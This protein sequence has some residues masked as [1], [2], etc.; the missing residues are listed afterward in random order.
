MRTKQLL[1]Y[2]KMADIDRLYIDKKDKELYEKLKEEKIFR[3]K[4]NKELFILALIYGYRNKVHREISNKEGF[5]RTEYLDEKDWALIKSI[6]IDHK[7]VEILNDKGKIVNIVQEYAH[8]GI[9]ILKSNLERSQYG[10]FDKLFE[11]ELIEEYKKL[12]F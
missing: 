8:M 2:Y 1:R 7:S 9:Q 4:S 6:A 11:R 5:V 3:G 12:H 10:S